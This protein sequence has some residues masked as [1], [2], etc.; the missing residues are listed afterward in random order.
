MPKRDV[1]T[2]FRLPA[3]LYDQV[4]DLLKRDKF[5]IYSFSDITIL[6]LDE[7]MKKY[8]NT[9][10]EAPINAYMLNEGAK[11]TLKGGK[12]GGIKK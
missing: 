8:T 4:K 11:T 1:K 7:F 6:A 5:K 10:T 9:S 12:N 3:E 2:S